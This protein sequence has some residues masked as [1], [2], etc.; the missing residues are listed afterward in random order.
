M[1]GLRQ[2]RGHESKGDGG[3]KTQADLGALLHGD[4]FRPL[5]GFQV[6]SMIGAVNCAGDD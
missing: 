1:R 2:V 5:A 3:G 6:E 4:S